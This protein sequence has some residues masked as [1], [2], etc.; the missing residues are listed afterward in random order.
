VATRLDY[1]YAVKAGTFPTLTTTAAKPGDIVVL[2]GTGLGPTAPS[3]PVGVAVPSTTIYSTAT[4]PTATL[5]GTGVMVYGAALS[6]GSAGLYQVAIQVPDTLADGD[7]PVQVSIGG[8]TSPKGVIL[9]V[10]H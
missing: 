5:N 7:W 10:Q 3:A 2:W 4:V 6:P 9:A 8:V 1:S